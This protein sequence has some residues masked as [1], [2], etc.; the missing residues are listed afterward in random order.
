MSLYSF[1]Y[2]GTYVKLVCTC[3]NQT[4]ATGADIVLKILLIHVK[5]TLIKK[6]DLS[7][8]SGCHQIVIFYNPYSAIAMK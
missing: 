7:C 8:Y 2:T 5:L 4:Y 3:S 1:P 6:S